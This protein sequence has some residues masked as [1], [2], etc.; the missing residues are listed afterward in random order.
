MEK[1]ES[2]IKM[3]MDL[4]EVE[5]VIST[6]KRENV[7][8]QL[9]EYKKILENNITEENKKIEDSFCDR[10][11]KKIIQEDSYFK[12]SSS[13][14]TIF[15]EKKEA[16]NWEN[17]KRKK[18]E[19]P[20]GITRTSNFEI[21]NEKDSDPGMDDFIQSL[22]KKREE[23]MKRMQNYIPTP[24]DSAG[25]EE[26]KATETLTQIN[27]YLNIKHEVYNYFYLN[28]TNKSKIN[29]VS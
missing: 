13:G 8:N 5:E 12:P 18:K 11:S 21:D 16:G 10:L 6:L 29:I 22:H 1:G 19:L 20:T 2:F 28:I 14:L 25:W 26:V 4:K 15:L 3:L 23:Q 24:D 27:K 17:L 7:K 9:S